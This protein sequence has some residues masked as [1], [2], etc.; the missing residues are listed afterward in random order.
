MDWGYI[1][2]GGLVLLLY[3]RAASFCEEK[4]KLEGEL[5]RERKSLKM[6]WRR[7]RLGRS[8]IVD[9]KWHVW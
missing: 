4:R 5:R 7:A 9:S 8:V 1:V 3:C 6:L 2:L